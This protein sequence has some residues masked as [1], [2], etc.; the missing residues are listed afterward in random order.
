MFGCVEGVVENGL[1]WVTGGYEFGDVLGYVK[2]GSKT[3]VFPI[4]YSR[5]FVIIP[6]SAQPCRQRRYRFMVEV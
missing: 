4:A 1:W 6:P 3:L 5:H 2:T